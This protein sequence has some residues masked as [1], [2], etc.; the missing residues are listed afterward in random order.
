MAAQ[1]VLGIDLGS[2]AI[3][4]VE[5]V[6]K[7]NNIALSSLGSIPTPPRGL[8]SDV[9]L[10]E[11][12]VIDVLVKL[13]KEMKVVSKGVHASLP[14]SNVF[15]RVIDLPNLT[16]KELSSSIKWEAEQYIP[17]PI[18][19]VNIDYAIISRNNEAN[20]MK[21][22]LIA[23][24]LTL[25]EKY[26]RIFE[27]AN[28]EILS[29]ETDAIASSRITPKSLPEKSNEMILN[30]GATT[31]IIG[32]VKDKSLIFV[33]TMSMAG[34]NLTR[35]IA[36]ELGFSPSQ[37]EEYK[38]TYGLDRNQLEGKI[39]TTLSPVFQQLMEEVKKVIAYFN[40]Q[41]PQE[42]LTTILLS[43]GSV[44]MPGLVSYIASETSL[45]TQVVNPFEDISFNPTQKAMIE[46]NAPYFT[47]AVGLG[48]KE[49]L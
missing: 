46:A 26:T 1:S 21:V 14:E 6:K 35:T 15:T 13:L 7:G 47:V 16:E 24:P 10:D 3:K 41:Y 5:L 30:I 12:A 49:W 32:I 40:G 38:R 2:N 23:A 20:S 17:L 9:P 25:I 4:I 48:I 45:D 18:D 31:S 42:K 27:S 33:R 39:F 8:I 29:L 22:L 36:D 34:N 43:G 19:K 37:A 44:R 11:Q 28:L